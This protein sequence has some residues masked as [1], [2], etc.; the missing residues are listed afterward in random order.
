VKID[1]NFSVIFHFFV[2]IQGGTTSFLLLKSSKKHQHNLWLGLLVLA[3]S[4]QTLDSF[5]ISSGIYRDNHSLYFA[6]FFYSWS[7][8]ALFYFYILRINNNDFKLKK[9]HLFHFAPV[10]LQLLFYTFVFIQNLEFKTNFWFNVH[11]PYTRNIDVYGGILLVFVYLYACY[12]EL[13]LTDR[14]LQRF[15]FSL[16]LFYIIAAIDPLINHLYL[17]EFSPKYY[18]IEVILPIFT[19]WLGLR[20]YLKEQQVPKVKKINLDINQENLQKIITVVEEKE[21]FLNPELSLS[22]VARATQLNVN[23][24]SNTINSGSGQS[25]NDF[26]NNYRIELVKSKLLQ[27]EHEKFT[28]L[29]IAFDAGFNSK[30][31]FNR[32]FKKS[33][34]ISPSEW[35][36]AN[37]TV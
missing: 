2:L 3:L 18:I 26:I 23:I 37:V 17:P 13:K 19:F 21:L 30:N 15:I 32:A 29:G 28:I 35:I 20:A 5:F 22:D 1:F 36:E 10:I 11:R 4:F 33:T 7:Y 8:G 31:T 16:I 24:V 14:K 6:P 27:K 25:F 34:G 12:D 9:Q